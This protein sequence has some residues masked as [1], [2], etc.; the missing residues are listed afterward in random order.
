[1]PT[2]LLIAIYIVIVLMPLLLGWLQDL[3]PRNPWDELATGLGMVALAMI[4]VEFVLL[5]RFRIVTAR[6]GSDVVMRSHQLLARAALF[7]VLA[8]PFLYVSAYAPAPVWDTTRATA[9]SHSWWALWPGIAAW[10]LLGGLVVMAIARDVSGARYEVWRLLHGLV[11]VL[12]AGLAVLHALRAGRYSADPVLAWAWIIMLGFAA[13]ALGYVYIVAP[14]LRWRR[15]W[16]VSAVRPVARRTWAITLAPEFDG[17]LTYHAGQ[18]AW[19]NI[20]RCAFSLNEN[21]FSISSAPASGPRVEF[22]IK[23]LG[24]FT[25]RIGDV[26]VGSRAWID[27]PHGSLTHVRHPCA[28]GIA[29]IAGGVGVAP[30]LG[31]LRDLHITGDAR[32]TV[33]L[34]GNRTEDQIVKREE[35]EALASGHGTEI[36]HVLSEPPAGWQGGTG[37]ID[38]GLLRRHFGPKERQ[39]WLYILCGP[40]PMLDTLEAA[41]IGLGV[42]ASNILSERFIYD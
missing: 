6:A 12:V 37:M 9:L 41:L 24:D 18:F 35:L 17:H 39:D 40:P 42:P 5:G 36:V 10:L 15:P 32:P 22:I 26:P 1:M 29:L 2:R 14:L 34:Y 11:A 13:L 38:A 30:L 28:S 4:L 23:E 3:P 7:F 33:L 27:A 19:L 21:P 20:G 16:R 31:I 25:D 8:H